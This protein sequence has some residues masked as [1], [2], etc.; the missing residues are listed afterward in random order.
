MQDQAMQH[1]VLIFDSLMTS[2]IVADEEVPAIKQFLKSTSE[3]LEGS[4]D[5]F[6]RGLEVVKAIPGVPMIGAT[7]AD[8]GGRGCD[9]RI[10]SSSVCVTSPFS[11]AAFRPIGLVERC[12]EGDICD[13]IALDC[14]KDRIDGRRHRGQREAPAP[15]RPG[16]Q[17]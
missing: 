6:G 4:Y 14:R 5:V 1:E 13:A 16:R 17:Q 9:A 10:V 12:G 2:L 15:E 7:F 8:R 11:C 3:H